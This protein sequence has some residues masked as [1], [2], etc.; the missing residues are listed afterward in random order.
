MDAGELVE[1]EGPELNVLLVPPSMNESG[2]RAFEESPPAALGDGVP[3]VDVGRREK[4]LDGEDG[5]K[6]VDQLGREVAGVV[7]EPLVDDARSARLGEEM[8]M[9]PE[10]STDCAKDFGGIALLQE[11]DGDDAGEVI[12]E[13][14]GVHELVNAPGQKLDGA[15]EV[16]RD[17]LTKVRVDATVGWVTR[18]AL[19][20]TIEE[21]RV[22][23]ATITARAKS[24]TFVAECT[25]HP[26]SAEVAQAGMPEQEIVVSRSGILV[27]DLK[28]GGVECIEDLG[29]GGSE[30][31]C[32]DG[33]GVGD[34][35]LRLRRPDGRD[36]RRGALDFLPEALDS[37]TG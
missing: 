26:V 31:G 14:D 34:G 12:D 5:A 3:L 18:M 32:I 15:I 16:G 1:E 24:V 22:A 23:D 35:R 7:G 33:E 2:A 19:A 6:F 11:V 37:G 8:S 36:A 25:N 28:Q 13:V 10:E 21:T 9:V 4:V 17:S 20:A 30:D 27:D 29:D